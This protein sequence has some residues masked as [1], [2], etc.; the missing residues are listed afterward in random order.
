MFGRETRETVRY[1]RRQEK[2]KRYGRAQSERESTH[3]ADIRKNPH[4]TP[5]NG[6]PN[7]KK[8]RAPFRFFSIPRAAPDSTILKSD[9]RATARRP[10]KALFVH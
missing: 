9:L 8:G 4:P 2:H 1:E 7:T 3:R 10:R 5:Q 6:L